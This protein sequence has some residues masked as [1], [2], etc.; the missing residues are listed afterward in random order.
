[1]LSFSALVQRVSAAA[2]LRVSLLLICLAGGFGAAAQVTFTGV[3]I[4]PFGGLGKGITVDSSGNVYLA[5]GSVV[6]KETP[7][8]QGFTQSTVVTNSSGL[9]SAVAVAVDSSGNV[10]IADLS[11]DQ[12]LKETLSGGT[13]TNSVIVNSTSGLQQPTGVAVDGSGNIYILDSGQDGVFQAV[14]GGGSYS[15][16]PVSTSTLSYP[17]GLAADSSGN[18]YIAD[19]NHSRVIKE[20]ALGGGSFTES[21]VANGS[22]GLTYPGGVGVDASGNV[23]ITDYDDVSFNAVYK[24]TYSGGSYTQSQLPF[25][26]LSLPSG[27]GVDGS[28]N[29]FLDDQ[30]NDRFLELTAQSVNF[31]SQ[32]VGSTSGPIA[33]NFSI[34]AGTTVGSVGVLTT[35]IASLDFTDAGKSACT[36]TTYA[37]DTSCSVNVKFTPASPGLRQGAVVFY[38]GANNSGTVLATVPIYGVGTGPLAIFVPG[39]ESALVS[40][41]DDPE[42]LAMDGSGDFF[43]VDGTLNNVYEEKLSGGSYTQ[44]TILSGLNEPSGIAVDGAGNLYIADFGSGNVYEETLSGGSYTQTTIGSG[45]VSPSGVALDGAGNVYVADFGSPLSSTP[46]PGTLYKETLSGG[47]YVQSAI[48]SGLGYPQDVTVDG[49]GNLYVT[50]LDSS[51]SSSSVSGSVYMETPSGAGYTES[52]VATGLVTPFG[53]AV[54]ASGNLYVADDVDFNGSGGIVYKETPSS[55]SYVQSILIS[56]FASPEFVVLDGSGNLYATDI[57]LAFTNSSYL[58][59]VDY[60]DA[61]SLS[62]PSVTN[63]G[64]TDTTDGTMTV[65]VQNIGNQLL[66]LTALSYPADFSAASSDLNPCTGSTSLSMGLLCD[67]PIQF[68]PQNIGSP[69]SE[70]VTLTDNSLNVAGAMQSVGVSGTS[71]AAGAAT[72]FTITGSPSPVAGAPFQVTISALDSS[73]N[74][75]TGYN[76][77]VTFSSS[78][79]LFVNPGPLTLTNGVGQVNVTLETAGTQTI[80]AMDTVFASLR[81]TGSFAVSAGPASQLGVFGPGSTLAG[82]SFSFTVIA[83]DA[84]QNVATTYSGT[85]GFSSSDAGATLPANTALSGGTGNFTA[86]LATVGSQTITATDTVNSSLTGTS[87]G[88]T[89]VAPPTLV[90]TIAADDAGTAGNCTPQTTPGVGTDAACSLRD[91]LAFSADAGAA[92]ISFDST[93]FSAPQ[94]ITLGSTGTLS[95]P[96][97]TT[98]TGPTSTGPTPTNL[99]TVDGATL[100]TVFEAIEEFYSGPVLNNLNIANGN[101]GPDPGGAGGFN[102]ALSSL[103][104]NNCAF[105]GNTGT[106]A[107]AIYIL[108]GLANV[109]GS[110]FSGNQSFG[111]DSSGD[112]DAGAIYNSGE[113]IGLVSKLSARFH[114]LAS[115]RNYSKLTAWPSVAAVKG[116]RGAVKSNLIPTG[117]PGTLTVI[118]ST[119]TSNSGYF[120]GGIFN[121]DGLLVSGSTFTGNVSTS[122]S[123]GDGD[124]GA[125]VNYSLGIDGGE[126][127]GLVSPR[128]VKMSH[129]KATGRM[130]QALAHALASPRG[131][132]EYPSGIPSIVN[133]TFSNNSGV[134]SGGVNN[135]GGNIWV[136]FSTFN[137]NTSSGDSFGDSDAGGLLSTFGGESIIANNTF[138]GNSS[139]SQVG[140]GAMAGVDESLLE[141]YGATASGNSGFF[142]GLYGDASANAYLF[143]SIVTGNTTT[144]TDPSSPSDPNVNG[145][146]FDPSIGDIV[147]DPNANLAPLGNY[148]GPTQTM[149]PLPGSSAICAGNLGTLTSVEGDA[150]VTLTVDQRGLPNTNSTY[151][152]YTSTPCADAGAVQTNYALAFTTQPPAVAIVGVPLSAS[153]VVTL[154]ESGS[155]FTGGTSAVNM[156]DADSVLSGGT[157]SASLSSGTATFTNLIFSAVETNDTLTGSLTLNPGLTPSLVIMTQPSNGVDVGVLGALTSPTPGLKTVLPSTDITFQWSAGTGVT[158]YRLDLGTTGPGADD[159]FTYRGTDTTATVS[160]IHPTGETVYARLS[161]YIY[162]QWMYNDYVYTAS[163]VPVKAVLTTP[164]PGLSTLLGSTNVNFQWTPGTEVSLYQLS[165]S[166]IGPGQSELFMYKGAATSATASTLQAKGQ[167]V[168]ARL[169]SDIGGVWQYNDYQYTESGTPVPAIL[170]SPTPGL[171]TVLGNNNVNFQWSTGTGVSLYQLNLGSSLGAS[172]LYTYKGTATSTTVPSLPANGQIVFARLYSKINGNWV[173]DDYQYYDDN[174]YSEGGT[175]VAAVLQSPTPGQGTVLGTNSVPFQWSTGTGVTLYQFTLSSVTSG[176]SDLFLYKG[177]ATSANVPSLPSNGALVYARLSSYIN[178]TWQHNDYVYTESGSTVAAV[179]TSPTPGLSTILGTSDVEFQWTTGTGVALY[180]LN[181]STVAPG[182]S[183]LFIYKGSATS[184]IA[185]TLPANGVTVYARLY[186]KINGV[187]QYNDYVYTEQ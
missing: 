38:S 28:G 81:G 187:W 7:G 65:Q 77:T 13:Y 139:S 119:F 54:D 79:P 87:S 148:G 162:G 144:N 129:S 182:Q 26:G 186:S 66:T 98:I 166:V 95:I 47:T 137:Q 53:I 158:Q 91:A 116:I 107:G 138:F 36:A 23:Y 155:I 6:Y 83:Y 14:Y 85:I 100:Y 134:Y 169:Y 180:Q 56:D 29:I 16:F 19:S 84:F 37:S 145:V 118:N 149:I 152:G 60:A 58:H 184:T 82:T 32:A 161:S 50:A 21:T 175:P 127:K 177:S 88:I 55:G 20:T 102:L 72:Q 141:S 154:T 142:G 33:V 51:T 67:L 174:G 10:Y 131:S 176:A 126:L 115:H 44:S 46:I 130:K 178:G 147:G 2:C 8:A 123:N 170:Q 112:G 86:T 150:G 12:V 17:T 27:I 164:T 52:T 185:P 151:P 25:S 168:Y 111:G 40:N 45:F 62:F 97:S 108:D 57:N 125:I 96:P 15:L 113:F 90:V 171:G 64:V 39:A 120:T 74:A 69:L 105:T 165:L 160:N 101:G 146:P 183:E 106:D 114:S 109:S 92:N 103:T 143:N 70:N 157:N 89:V 94:T 49:S 121:G 104:L 179:L 59:K 128:A 42:G 159:V 22:N 110:T 5:S 41:F 173:Y 35:G 172:D 76:G 61:P 63:V 133:S 34:A 71:V 140:A 156:T 43:V 136:A 124:G 167:I 11:N 24:E 181:L 132:D 3:Q 75:V 30:G 31:G 135:A 1:M 99:V 153:P 163:P 48:D 18:L 73:N 68:T 80:T 78:D 122:D 4:T 117:T 93:A 9:G